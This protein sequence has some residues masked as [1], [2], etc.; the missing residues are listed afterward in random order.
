M[1]E[2]NLLKELTVSLTGYI[3]SLSRNQYG[4]SR[5]L[6]IRKIVEMDLESDELGQ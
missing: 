1:A 2:N 5:P 4:E 6:K 3:N